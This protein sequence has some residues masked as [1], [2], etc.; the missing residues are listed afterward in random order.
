MVGWA[1]VRLV[2]STLAFFADFEVDALAIEEEA[3]LLFPEELVL[4]AI[5]TMF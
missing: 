1:L 3:F 2:E 5:L 4:V